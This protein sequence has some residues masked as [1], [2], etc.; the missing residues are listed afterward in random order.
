MVL[1]LATS[2]VFL[3]SRRK[4]EQSAQ[5]LLERGGGGRR[6]EK[7]WFPSFVWALTT[8]LFKLMGREDIYVLCS[9]FRGR[10][11]GVVVWFSSFWKCL[12]LKIGMCL[13][14]GRAGGLLRPNC[15]C[16]HC[17]C[18]LVCVIACWHSPCP[19]LLLG[20]LFYNAIHKQGSC[21]LLSCVWTRVASGVSTCV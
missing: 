2:T 6:R 8:S 12:S 15:S 10:Y 20:V 18:L 7:G 11:V 13:E 16:G 5:E 1:G 14:G 9:L 17:G 3:Q 4:C 21:G 19:A